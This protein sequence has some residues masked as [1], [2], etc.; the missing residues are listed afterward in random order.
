VR[1]A[2]R[3]QLLALLLLLA[4][5]ARGAEPGSLSGVIRDEQGVPL[6]GARITLS[7]G[8]N[9]ANAFSTTSDAKGGYHF[10]AIPPG[11]YQVQ[12]S[13]SGFETRQAEVITISGVAAK[14]LSLN[15]NPVRPQ[16]ESAGVRG[17]IDPGGYSASSD[18]AAA[19]G[20]IKGIADMKRTGNDSETAIAPC[21]LEPA[22]KKGVEEKPNSA[23]A[24]LK[25]GEFYLAH[26]QAANAIP[27]LENARSL[28]QGGQI[29]LKPLVEAYLKAGRF[30]SALQLLTPLA[31]PHGAPW[32]ARLLA[33]ASEGAGKFAEAAQYYQM[34]VNQEP[35]EEDLFGV[36]YELILAG[37]PKDAER[38]FE[39][40]LKRYPRSQ[41]LLIG[42]GSAQFLGGHASESV[43][44]MLRAVDSNPADPRPYPFLAAASTISNVDAEQVRSAFEHFLEI[45]PDNPQAP[46]DYAL[47]LLHERAADNAAARIEALLQRAILLDPGMADAHLQLGALY[48]RRGDYQ[49]ATQE[50]ENAVRLSPNLPEGHYRLALA[51]RQTGRKDLSAREMQRFHETQAASAAQMAGGDMSID[52]F[53]SV[54]AG[55]EAGAGRESL[56]PGDSR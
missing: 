10:P 42:F 3:I 39:A 20:L 53:I 33:R 17:L 49:H 43:R 11:S 44:T 48:T 32:A 4:C 5:I 37:L 46:Y 16:F 38:A 19:S 34:A 40:G 15:R 31:G 27:I 54:F 56:C 36:G 50:L 52:Q 35:T 51:Y 23:G 9:S 41:Q 22:L 2:P 29:A 26:G 8:E 30:D 47:N 55:P 13:L 45:A 1:P 18:A 14:D 12:A 7:S 28:D 25:L 24:N 6:E 21:A